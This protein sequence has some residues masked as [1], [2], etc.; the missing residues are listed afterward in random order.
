[1]IQLLMMNPLIAHE[2]TPCLRHNEGCHA[3][4][5]YPGWELNI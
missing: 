3:V 4:A 1:M 2:H 5:T